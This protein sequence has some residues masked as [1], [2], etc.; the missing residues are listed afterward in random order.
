MM[1]I[2]FK[3]K[4]TNKKFIFIFFLINF[5]IIL[6]S[7]LIDKKHNHKYKIV[8]ISYGNYKYL[9]QLKNKLILN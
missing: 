7:I 5:Y 9:K 8:A 2:N 1:N 4:N 6:N 3:L